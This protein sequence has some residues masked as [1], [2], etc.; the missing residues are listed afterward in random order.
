[1]KTAGWPPGRVFAAVEPA[2][3][4]QRQD[5]GRADPFRSHPSRA[6]PAGTQSL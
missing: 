3:P 5:R 4:T 6:S 1:M 2:R